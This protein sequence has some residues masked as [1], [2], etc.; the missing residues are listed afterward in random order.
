MTAPMQKYEVLYDHHGIIV[1]NKAFSVPSQPNKRGDLDVYTLLTKQYPY[2]GQHHRLD[3]TASGLMLFSTNKSLNHP[4]STA[5]K[6]HSIERQY[7]IWVVGKP[8]PSG[9]WKQ[10]LDGKKAHTDFTLLEYNGG[11]S[12]LTINLHTGRTHQIRR[13]AQLNGLPIV[14]D[15][16]Y[17]G[18]AK[19]LWSRLALHAHTLKFTHPSTQELVMIQAPLP[20]DLTGILG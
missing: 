3:Q 13:H 8:T 4:L 15:R 20:N 14:G 19:R 12:K 10:S 9:S 16:K 18:A 1:V 7:W 5:F 11:I 6:T 17:G 2:V